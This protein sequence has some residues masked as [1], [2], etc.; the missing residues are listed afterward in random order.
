M[1]KNDRRRM[2]RA[3]EPRPDMAEVINQMAME[4]NARVM[5]FVEVQLQAIQDATGLSTEQ[6]AKSYQIEQDQQNGIVRIIRVDSR[7]R[8]GYA[9]KTAIVGQQFCIEC[10]REETNAEAE[11]RLTN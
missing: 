10:I 7:Q 3:E 8:I 1:R 6:M 11:E 9:V 2:P 5:Q 4:A